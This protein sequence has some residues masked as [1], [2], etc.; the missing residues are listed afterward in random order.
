MTSTRPIAAVL[1]ALAVLVLS[2]CA[3][4]SDDTN[5]V[6]AP[7]D[8]NGEWVVTRTIV[9]TNNPAV[10]V[11]SKSKRYVQFS[12]I[13]CSGQECSGTALSGLKDNDSRVSTSVASI[14]NL[15][16]A[17]YAG[18]LD[19]LSAKG[20]DVVAVG[21][22]SYTDHVELTVGKS[23]TS[24]TGLVA[25]TLTGTA[26]YSDYI[27]D[28]ALVAGCSRDFRNSTTIYTLSAKRA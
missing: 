9:S 27:T 28:A 18:V 3:P 6:T 7:A 25:T 26:T 16:V 10:K 2:A 1:A 24:K 12:D 20:D 23:S 5:A 21:G 15:T 13:T 19:C 8:I 17:D 14:D 4:A 22:F 11:G